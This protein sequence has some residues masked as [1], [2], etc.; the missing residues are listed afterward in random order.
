MGFG[1]FLLC[2]GFFLT[3]SLSAQ[4]IPPERLNTVAE[5]L[6]KLGPEKVRANPRL[7]EALEKVLAGTRGTERFVELVDAFQLVARGPDLLAQAVAHPDE[8]AGVAA[9][10]ALLGLRQS[11]LVLN[12][13]EA[14]GTNAVALAR[15][16]GHTGKSGVLPLLL[17][18][19]GGGDAALAK[20]CVRALAL[21][22]PGA[23]ALLQLAREDKLPDAVKLTATM[24]L[25]AVRWPE[26]RDAAAKVLPLP[27]GQGDRAL[28]PIAEL[29]RRKG[30]ATR[31]AE[32][33]ARETVGCARC[34]QIHG[35]GV[36]FGPALSEIGS[37]LTREALYE[38]ILAPSSGISMGFEAW[39]VELKDGDEFFGVLVSD[40]D[41]EIVLKQVGGLPARIKKSAITRRQQS[42]LSSM[43]AGLQ[44]LMTE[45]EL[46]DLIE[47][48]AALKSG[49]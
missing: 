42:K 41:E 8:P 47:Y 25:N 14:G 4:D 22:R 9:M 26:V 38:S 27:Q 1:V 28:P 11:T 37:K 44:Q 21:T 39:T 43:P 15:C 30:D 23:G 18:F 13:L 24:E 34:H 5:A 46:V 40:T 29:V 3:A 33:F 45:Q 36:D 49:R 10:N 2:L 6:L 16:L 12:A 19:V 35:R 31:G 20:E 48:L 32:V 7:V 17:P